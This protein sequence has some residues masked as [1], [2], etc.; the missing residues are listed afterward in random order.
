MTVL[1]E[2]LILWEEFF[3]KHVVG[4]LI[5]HDT[6]LYFNKAKAFKALA[7]TLLHW[8]FFK[9][10]GHFTDK[11]LKVFVKH[12]LG[13]TPNLLGKASVYKPQKVHLGHYAAPK[14]IERRKR[15][16]IDLQEL[17]AINPRL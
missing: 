3:E 8:K 7:K 10:L 6:G 16:L 4:E 15:K 17:V 9:H 5:N 12:L 13:K 14:W 1:N 2:Y 11:D